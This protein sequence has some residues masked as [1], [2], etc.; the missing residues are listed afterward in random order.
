MLHVWDEN[1]DDLVNFK[2][3]LDTNE[4]G[5]DYTDDFGGTSNITGSNF[6]YIVDDYD[7]IDDD[8]SAANNNE[9][10]SQK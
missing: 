1:P 9:N 7:I 2:H 3:S 10:N 4:D 8:E 5:D 6:S